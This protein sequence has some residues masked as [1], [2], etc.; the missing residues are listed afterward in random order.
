[1][2]IGRKDGSYVH[3]SLKNAGIVDHAGSRDV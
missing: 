1:M 3:V 2:F